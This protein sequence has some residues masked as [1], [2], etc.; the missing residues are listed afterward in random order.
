MSI[1]EGATCY[2]PLAN[3]MFVEHTKYELCVVMRG[4]Q[5]PTTSDGNY[6]SGYGRADCPYIKGEE[7]AAFLAAWKQYR[8]QI[9]S[10]EVET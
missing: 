9:D 5:H 1:F 8:Q 6:L 3:V 10:K 4:A 7:A 2:I